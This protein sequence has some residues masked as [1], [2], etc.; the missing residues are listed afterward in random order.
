[1]KRYLFYLV[2]PSKIHLFRVSIN[3]LIKNGHHVDVVIN[4]KD[5]LEDLIKQEDWKYTNIFPEGRNNSPKPSVIK[6]ALKFLLTIVRLELYL[7]KQKRYDVFVTDDSLVVN[8]IWRKT[9]SFLFNDNDIITIKINKILFYFAD[10]IVSPISTDLGKFENKKIAFK[11]NKALAHLYPSIFFPDSQVL[12]KNRIEADKYCIIRTS[13]LNAT[14]DVGSNV[15]I[16]D[17]NLRIL[18]DYVLEK[19]MKPFII[20]ERKLDNN[21]DQY[22]FKGNPKDLASLIFYSLFV[23]TD[24]GT[25]ATE[26]AVLGIPN[27][28]INKLA[29]NVGVHNELKQSNLQYYYDEFD[30]FFIEFNNFDQLSSLKSSFQYHKA[31]YFQ[32]KSDINVRFYE[33]FTSKN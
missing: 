17:F 22:I 1:M 11:G 9:K 2:H 33:I 30:S 31:N 14:H 6:S 23:V 4:S 29:K 26:A 12:E 20:T 28:L 27:F 15:G 7:I 8:G 18:V 32:D 16:N 21:L 25:I 24:S 10:Y 3:M 5:V 19:N 13:L